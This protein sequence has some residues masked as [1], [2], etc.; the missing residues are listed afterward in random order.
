MKSTNDGAEAEDRSSIVAV[1][2]KHYRTIRLI[3]RW[4]T[5]IY[6]VIYKQRESRWT[7]H[8][9]NIASRLRPRLRPLHRGAVTPTMPVLR[10]PGPGTVVRSSCHSERG[11]QIRSQFD[12]RHSG[13][14]R[15]ARC[16]GV[17][18]HLS[19]N[20]AA[21]RRH[22][23]SAGVQQV[24]LSG[25]FSHFRGSKS[26]RVRGN[27]HGIFTSLVFLYYVRATCSEVFLFL[28][29]IVH[30]YVSVFIYCPSC[31]TILLSE[32]W[33]KTSQIC[34][35]VNCVFYTYILAYGKNL[36]I[37]LKYLKFR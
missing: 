15:V 12:L 25:R 9:Q 21:K 29:R 6:R 17:A 20:C 26:G 32:K 30:T 8:V 14:Q 33:W 5:V 3:S 27:F 1:D 13:L 34:G 4:I 24:R 37:L 35:I 16:T 2:S 28:S 19:H 10:Q 22:W 36:T 7:N 23:R 31:V 11:A 18:R